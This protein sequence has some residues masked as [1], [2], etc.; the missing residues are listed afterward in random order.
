MHKK[1]GFTLIE[2]LVVIAIIA[3]L[4]SILMPAMRKVKEQ[5]NMIKCMGNLKQWNLIYAMYLQNNDGKFFSGNATGQSGDGF[6]W[7][8]QMAEKEQSRI[9]NP[10][11]FCPKTKGTFRDENGNPNNKFSIYTAWGIFNH[12][13]ASPDGIAGSYGINGWV[14]DVPGTGAALS[15][16]RTRADHWKTPNVAQAAQI[17]MMAEALRFDL[18]PQPTNRPFEN[19]TAV[20]S[21]DNT[22]HM[23]RAC[24]NRHIGYTNVS[25][26]DFSAR[27]VG[28]KELYTLKWHRSFNTRGPWTVAGGVSSSDWPAWIRPFSDY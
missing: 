12:A 1:R 15:E 7:I 6:W 17:P 23:A 4:L 28:L 10:L 22:N 9:D 19:E 27:K 14:L 2:L 16:G 8:I 26:C 25:M 13:Q 5:G 20:W 3:L 18:W 21:T 11:W 24:M